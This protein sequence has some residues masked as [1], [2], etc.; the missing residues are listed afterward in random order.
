[1]GSYKGINK[2]GLSFHTNAKYKD[3]KCRK[4]NKGSNIALRDI[5]VLCVFP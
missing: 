2:R 5:G 1:M 3:K 4:I